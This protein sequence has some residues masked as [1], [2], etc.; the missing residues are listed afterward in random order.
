[1]VIG[2]PP[3]EALA[4]DAAEI[5]RLLAQALAAAREAGIRGKDETPFLLA[6]LARGHG[7]P[8]GGAERGPCP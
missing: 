1:M 6:Q 7:R 3:P 2:N 4:L 5:E 8:R